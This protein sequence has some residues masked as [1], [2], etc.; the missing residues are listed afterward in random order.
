[1][2][3]GSQGPARSIRRGA[4]DDAPR[5]S[6]IARAAKAHWGYPAEWLADWADALTIPPE[7]LAEHTVFVAQDEEVVGFCALEDHGTAW[8]L[9]HLWVDPAHHGRGLGA[10]LMRRAL[11]EV[12]ALGPGTVTVVSDPQAAPFYLRLGARPAG[13][14]PAPM[15]GAPARELPVFE[16]RIADSREPRTRVWDE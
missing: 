13:T 3:R 8:A 7:Y 16:W 15:P 2:K 14:V 5:L 10:A 1:M 9:E 11:D 6:A 4:P 12:R